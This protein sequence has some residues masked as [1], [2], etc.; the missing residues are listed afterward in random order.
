MKVGSQS[1]TFVAD[2]G[3]EHFMETTPLAPL[4]GRTATIFGATG[5]W[6]PAHC[7]RPIRVS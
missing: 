3:A 7:A 1:M 2:T 5:T 4:T 6:Q